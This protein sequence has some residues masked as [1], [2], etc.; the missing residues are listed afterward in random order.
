MKKKDE[1]LFKI[2]EIA[3]ILGV[4]RKAILVY[5]EK[6]LLTPAVKDK[7]SG[8]R[9]YTADNMTQIRSI[10]S[11]Q[12]LG[13]SLQ[14]I[15]DYYYNTDNI[16]YHL[17]KL[18]GLRAMLDRNIQMLQVRAA[19]QGDM[20]VHYTTLPQQVCYCRRYS[21][22]D[23]ADATK[24]LHDTYIEAARTGRM[25]MTARMF[26]MR[27]A[28]DCDALDLMCCIPVDADYIGPERMEFAETPA[29][30]VY[31]RGPYEGTGT[32]IHA[33]KNYIDERSIRTSG[34]FRSI[35]LEGPPNRGANSADY[36]TQI[37]VAISDFGETI[38]PILT[39]K[40]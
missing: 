12:A 3:Q 25:S 11:L 4:T 40:L 29:L 38:R 19:K 37:A 22:R 30:C 18:M 27:M 6:G 33:L 21:C 1:N 34:P 2:G 20:T 5:E 10:R 26:T 14:E 15:A 28:Q 13:L 24:H 9:Y 17:Q 32:A 8:Y 36:I 35:Y 23:V 39:A 7:N 16:E 31:Y